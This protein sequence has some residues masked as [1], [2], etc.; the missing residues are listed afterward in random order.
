MPR[1][2]IVTMEVEIDHLPSSE[3]DYIEEYAETTG[4]SLVE[5]AAEHLTGAD[6]SD[7]AMCL[8]PSADDPEL[9]AGSM[10]YLKVLET[11]ITS[12]KW[13]DA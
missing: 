6:A 4:Q 1:K 7:V 9:F 3:I 2:L 5:I 12:A 8:V 13:A 10:L 11:A